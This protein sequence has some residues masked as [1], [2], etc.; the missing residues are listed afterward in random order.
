MACTLLAS[1]AERASR[2]DCPAPRSGRRPC[3]GRS[4]SN[5]M[6]LAEEYAHFP[7]RGSSAECYPG[8][9]SC[10]EESVPEVAEPG[11]DVLPL[12]EA[13]VEGRGVHDG[14]GRR[15]LEVGDALG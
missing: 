2:L 9:S 13:A 12:V 4:A 6:L 15:G 5:R 14:V 10:S 1:S 3:V 11:Q 8:V 7:M